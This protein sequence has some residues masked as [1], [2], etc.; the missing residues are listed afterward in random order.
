[1][2]AEIIRAYNIMGHALSDTKHWREWAKAWMDDNT[3][4][5][6]QYGQPCYRIKVKGSPWPEWWAY[7]N[8]DGYERLDSP[9]KD[10]VS[11]GRTQN[12]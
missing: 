7:T 2:T 10:L 12:G 1:M 6:G 5:I 3:P 11:E 4:K 9:I 8:D